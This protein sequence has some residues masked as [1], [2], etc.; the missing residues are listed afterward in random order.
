VQWRGDLRRPATLD[1]VVEVLQ[2]MG[3]M[4]MAISANV[5]VIVTE[6]KGNDD[7]EEDA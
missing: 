3:R 2:G 4:L 6:I 1:D 5:Q 7:E